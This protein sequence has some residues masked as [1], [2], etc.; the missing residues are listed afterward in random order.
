MSVFNDLNKDQICKDHLSRCWTTLFLENLKSQITPEW[1][2]VESNKSDF[3]IFQKENFKLCVNLTHTLSGNYK[4]LIDC[5]IS[6]TVVKNKVFSTLS[7]WPECYGVYAHDFVYRDQ[8]PIKKFN[9]FIYRGCPFR[10]SWMYQLVRR[11]LL[12]QGYVT[13]WCEDR[14]NHS[15]P[16]EHF[17]KLFQ[18]NLNFGKEHKLLKGKIPFKTFDFELE[19]AIIKSE[20]TLI[21][22][23][24]FQNHTEIVLSEKI[25]R[26]IQLP[27]PWL[28][29]GVPDS[30][31]VLRDWG[32]DVF[33]DV[34]D[35]SYDSNRDPFQ[36]QMMILDQLD[37]KI[38]Y[39]QSILENFRLRSKKNQQLLEKFY[40]QWPDKQKNIIES[41]KNISTNESFTS[42][43]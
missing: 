20:K 13:Y 7:L 41:I 14:F 39:N 37:T 34:V 16:Q 3:A 27:R 1:T 24:F 40:Q 43:T 6:D 10:Q 36:R 19:D 5:L 21:I 31:A 30:V 38:E 9:C 8:L 42:R 29:F 23:T 4:N 11:K 35:H 22:E 2:L 28:L 25:W 15:T 32:F 17:E 18:A 12:D 26:S 33:D